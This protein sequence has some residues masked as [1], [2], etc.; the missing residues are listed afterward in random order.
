MS[1]ARRRWGHDADRQA[2]QAIGADIAAE[3]RRRRERRQHV[4]AEPVA[5]PLPT[6]REQLIAAGLLQPGGGRPEAEGG[7]EDRDA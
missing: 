3:V 6:M 7:L 1:R 2:A 5:R 4:D